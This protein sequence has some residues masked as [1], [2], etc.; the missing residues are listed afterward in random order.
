MLSKQN[1]FSFTQQIPK[2]AYA[3]RSFVVRLAE[4]SKSDSQF[5]IVV[6]KKI[7][8]RAAERNRIKRLYK[9]VLF[10]H[11]SS[12]KSSITAV[13]YVRKP[14]TVV[15]EEQ[16]SEEIEKIFKKEGIINK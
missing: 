1:R 5:A 8:N 3:S 9:G 16:L 10:Q 13:F 15:T 4:S 12:F 7:D 14:S 2:Q 6:S 11:M